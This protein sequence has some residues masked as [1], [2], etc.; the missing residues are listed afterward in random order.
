MKAY[1]MSNTNTHTNSITKLFGH[2]LPLQSH[3]L[4][5]YLRILNHTASTH[6]FYTTIAPYY[7]SEGLHSLLLDILHAAPSRAAVTPALHAAD[8]AAV[9]QLYTQQSS[10]AAIYTAWAAAYQSVLDSVS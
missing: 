9:K 7:R 10:P 2:A 5:A 8:T 3:Q 1:I 6:T 4:P